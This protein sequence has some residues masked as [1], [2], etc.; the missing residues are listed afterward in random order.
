MIGKVICDIIKFVKLYNV[1]GA[2]AK[3]TLLST[4]IGILD[5][6]VSNYTDALAMYRQK[7][8]EA[9]S[10]LDSDRLQSRQSLLRHYST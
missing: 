2:D 10:G 9:L 4:Q 6:E 8:N 1:F 5:E 7:A 3:N